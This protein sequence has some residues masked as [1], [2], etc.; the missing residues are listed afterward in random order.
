MSETKNLFQNLDYSEQTAI[1]R[2]LSNIYVNID[3]N[4]TI[5]CY[6]ASFNLCLDSEDLDAV[7]KLIHAYQGKF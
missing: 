1:I 6:N 7:L 2:L 5:G 3:Y 4:S